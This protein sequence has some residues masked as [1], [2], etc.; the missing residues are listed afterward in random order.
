MER[1]CGPDSEQDMVPSLL[2]VCVFTGF[3]HIALCRPLPPETAIDTT[4]LTTSSVHDWVERYMYVAIGLNLLAAVARE[5]GF[6]VRFFTSKGA[7]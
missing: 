6:N 7:E 4:T 3:I 1:G 2:E 5:L